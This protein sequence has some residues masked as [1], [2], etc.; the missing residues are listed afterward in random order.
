MTATQ[1]VM[2]VSAVVTA[3]S[4]LGTFAYIRQTA[5]D[6]RWSRRALEG[7]KHSD[8]LIERVEDNEQRS[9]ANTRAL[10][11]ADL[12]TDGGNR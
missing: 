7:E 9:R 6:A 3:L 11:D 2:A 1:V 10:R 5:R 4:A 8:G 12:R